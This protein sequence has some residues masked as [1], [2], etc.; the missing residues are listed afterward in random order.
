MFLNPYQLTHYDFCKEMAVVCP[1]CS[2]RA[3]VE[4]PGLF[5]EDSDERTDCICKNCNYIQKYSEKQPDTH[6][7]NSDGKIIS[8]RVK[9]LS[10]EIDPFFHYPLWY[11]THYIKG[12]IWAYNLLHLIVIEDFIQTSQENHDPLATNNSIANRLPG[13]MRDPIH[14]NNVLRCIKQL[15]KK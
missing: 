14:K 4:G 9:I 2:N 10:G 6:R 13:W 1:R 3:Q 12:V 15:K 7:R 5:A 11:S 8:Y